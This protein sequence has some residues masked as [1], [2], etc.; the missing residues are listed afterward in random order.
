MIF[1]Y[2]HF[3]SWI[4]NQ[5]PL[6]LRLM[7]SDQIHMSLKGVHYVRLRNTLPRRIDYSPS[8]HLY[9]ALRLLLA[10]ELPTSSLSAYYFP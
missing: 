8:P 1:N 10:R 5:I 4:R 2:T 3:P 7:L 6:M 9:C